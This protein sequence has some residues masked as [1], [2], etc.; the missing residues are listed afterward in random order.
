[1]MKHLLTIGTVAMTAISLN[2]QTISNGGF[3]NWVDQGG[4]EE[5][6]SWG[7][8]NFFTLLGAPAGTTQTSDA[9]SGDYAAKIETTTFDVDSDGLDDTLPGVVFLG[10]FDLMGGDVVIG[11]PFTNRP[12][13]LIGWYK[14]TTT[15]TDDAFFVEVALTKWNSQNNISEV[16]A[17]IEYNGTTEWSEYTR[18]ALPLVYSNGEIPDSVQ[19]AVSTDG[20]ST[21]T[22]GTTVWVDDLS[23]VTNSAAALPEHTSS[24]A[25]IQYYPNPANQSMT[26]VAPKNTVI[27]VYNALGMEVET[28]KAAASEK[29]MLSTAN[30]RNGVYFLK[31][32][33][34]EL[35][36]FVVQH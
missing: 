20:G 14:F 17:T 8:L 31:A 5:P 26:I 3:E 13:S 30:Y 4:Y 2:A 10:E 9:H 22:P 29:T 33:S 7:T 35:E 36:R 27:H 12:D 11:A 19:I 24:I 6:Q 21:F 1:M 28:V 34:G 32:E 16:V 15:G 25:T 18:L 23:F